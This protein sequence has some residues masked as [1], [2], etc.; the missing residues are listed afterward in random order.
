MILIDTSRKDIERD[1]T[2]EIKAYTLSVMMLEPVVESNLYY[3]KRN[4]Q[5]RIENGCPVAE[6]PSLFGLTQSNDNTDKLV[7]YLFGTNKELENKGKRIE[8]LSEELSVEYT[9]DVD[10]YFATARHLYLDI[11]KPY[12]L[13]YYKR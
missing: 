11:S 8:C 3:I 4:I 6:I 1:D 13:G 12:M 2:G 10:E 5:W 9:P 7:N